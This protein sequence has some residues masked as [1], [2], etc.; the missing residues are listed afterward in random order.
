MSDDK[1]V[2]LNIPTGI[3]LVYNLNED[4][5]PLTKYYLGDAAAAEAKAAAVANQAKAGA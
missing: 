3:P 1:I 4:L 5:K 2:D